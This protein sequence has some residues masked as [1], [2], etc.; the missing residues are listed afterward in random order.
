[1]DLIDLKMQELSAS[2]SLRFSLVMP[3]LTAPVRLQ[4]EP[5]S[6]L[7]KKSSFKFVRCR[8]VEW[9]GERLVEAAF[10]YPHADESNPLA[11]ALQSGIVVLDPSRFWCIRKYEGKLAGKDFVGTVKHEMTELRQTENSI[12]VPRKADYMESFVVQ[13]RF[14]NT[15]R[16][17]THYDLDV[18][19]PLPSDADFTLTAFGLPEPLGITSKQPTPWYAWVIGAGIV[20]V[21]GGCLLPLSAAALFRQTPGCL[22]VIM[23]FRLVPNVLC[24]LG[25]ALLSSAGVMYLAEVGQ[26]CVTIDDAERALANLVPGS[27][28]EVHFPIRNPTWHNARIV[29]LAEC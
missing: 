12:L 5:L 24:L 25:L 17:Q 28:V 19:R 15:K 6:E 27:S 18:R 1:V 4:A 9:Q 14:E 8:E 16:F 7:I 22:G 10:E 3:A 11:T 21:L 26:S 2:Y 13:K 29:G 23:I 20:L